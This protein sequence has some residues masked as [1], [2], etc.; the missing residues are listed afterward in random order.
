MNAI[1]QLL[2]KVKSTGT[3]LAGQVKTVSMGRERVF[4]AYNLGDDTF[5]FERGVSARLAERP[6]VLVVDRRWLRRRGRGK[7]MT[8]TTGNH[9]V[10][11]MPLLDGRFWKLSSLPVSRRS[12]VMT[13]AILCANIVDGRLEVSQRDVP[14]PELVSLDRWLVDAAGLGLGGVVMLDRNESA[15]DHY[16]RLGQEWR[17]K[18]LVWTEKEL[19]TQLAA[20]R[21]R[22]FS[23]TRY[24]HS[25]RG[26]HFL[27]YPE[28]MRLVAL[29]ETAPADFVAGLREIVSIFEG[30]TVSFARMPKYRGHHEIEFF[31]LGRGVGVER[32]VPELEK[33][34]EA[35]ALGRLGQLGVIQ[36][37]RD[38]AALYESLLTTPE[39]ADE[40]SPVFVEKLYMY[41]TGEVYSVVGDG[42]TPS[43]DDRRTA[44]PGATFVGGRPVMHP[45][46]DVRSEVLLSNLRGLL[47][48]DELVEYANI[49]ELRE[50]DSV[51]VGRGRTREVV[52][53]TNMRPLATSL[54][55]KGLSSR[56]RGYAEYMLARIGALRAMGVSMSAYYRVL[57]RRPSTRSA[58]SDFYIRMRCE[59]EPIESIPANWFRSGEDSSV[60]VEDVVLGLAA[61]MGDAAAQNMAMK[62]FDPKTESPL[63]GVGKEIYEFEYDIIKEQVVP[64]KV[65]TCSIRGSF[66]WPDLSFTDQN[67]NAF[68]SFYFTHFAHALK[69]FCRHHTVPMA[70]LAE[71]FMSGFE[72]RT[73]A[74]AWQLSVMRDGFES[75]SPPVPSAYR[76]TEKWRF[77]MW[78]LERQERRLPLLRKMFF[79]RVALVQGESSGT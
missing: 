74:M 16:R 35:V 19:L 71:R 5:V 63:Y 43:F 34:M 39:F 46:A 12:D 27:T 23:K 18:P 62:K 1:R 72:F 32:I 15:L 50:D 64:K 21:K 6:S 4:E 58:P 66:G 31:G 53:K 40:S 2:K 8:V 57:R 78:A 37:A 10:A 29:A 56:R 52:Y 59:G 3:R 9:A 17:V 13:S 68:A 49:Y 69:D 36:K 51:P 22:I 47:S 24:Y 20:S 28:F 54:I 7:V 30:N 42:S 77:A 79:E 45:G 65:A 60:E 73:R 11:A 76:F 33:L 55:E 44:L 25:S 75:F 48:K 67:V 41:V 38:A 61:L 26:V 14:T 70:D